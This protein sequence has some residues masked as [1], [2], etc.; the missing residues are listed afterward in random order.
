MAY[1]HFKE[2]EVRGLNDEF[3][4][5]LDLATAKTAELSIEKR[6]IPF[7][8]T[9]GFRSPEKNQSVIGAIAD[10]SHLS[11]HAVDLLVSSSH[12]VAVMVQALQAAGINR[13]G[14]YVNKYWQPI[15]LHC[16]DD[17]TKVAQ[18]LF[19]KKEKN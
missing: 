1:K 15:H 18:V 11:G 5:K 10:S 6:R 7:I 19:V 17:P 13:I 12:E 9:S 8:I 16:D 2:S 3:V 4:Q 14:I